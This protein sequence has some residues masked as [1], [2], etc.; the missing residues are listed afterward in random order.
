M[1]ISAT[2]YRL[3]AGTATRG[4]R[5]NLWEDQR[6]LS[7]N[8]PSGKS[9]HLSKLIVHVVAFNI[10]GFWRVPGG[11]G[12]ERELHETLIKPM[13]TIIFNFS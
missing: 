9:K 8:Y 3:P 1:K 6:S 12:S 2:R 13:E 10:S 5:D 4:P 11:H 7:V